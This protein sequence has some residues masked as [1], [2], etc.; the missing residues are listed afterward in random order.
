MSVH[1]A[2]SIPTSKS[3]IS[4]IDDHS[5]QHLYKILPK[6]GANTTQAPTVSEWLFSFHKT[7]IQIRGIPQSSFSRRLGSNI[8]SRMLNRIRG[9]LTPVIQRDGRRWIRAFATTQQEKPNLYVLPMFPYPSGKAHMGHV[10]VFVC[11]AVGVISRYSISD[12]ITRY[13]R[14]CGYNV[15]PECVCNS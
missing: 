12:C 14:M 3:W 13:K 6:D 8:G 7:P 15:A 9:G 4:L 11:T 1:L 5:R 10:R 2:T